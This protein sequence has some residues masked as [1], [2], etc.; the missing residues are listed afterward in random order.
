MGSPWYVRNTAIHRGL[1]VP[2]LEVFVWSLA[3]NLFAKAGESPY[4][5]LRRLNSMEN[6][7][8]PR[9]VRRPRALLDDPPKFLNKNPPETNPPTFWRLN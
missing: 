2:T 5:H 1:R 7:P 8:P 4:P 3:T 6:A 9:R